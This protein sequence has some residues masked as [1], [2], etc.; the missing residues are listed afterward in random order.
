VRLDRIRA[1]RQKPGLLR[2][3]LTAVRAATTIAD[4]TVEGAVLGSRALTFAPR[5]VRAGEYTF[6]VGSAG[7][8]TLVLQTVLP[9]LLVASGSSVL[10]LEGGTH[11]PAAPPLT[12]E[13]VFVAR[14]PAGSTGRDDDRSKGLLSRGRRAIHRAHSAGDQPAAP[15]S[16]RARRDHRTFGTR[17]SPISRN[18]L[19]TGNWRRRCIS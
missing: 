17:S 15:R 9:A 4:A 1:G 10:T 7:S 18:T 12:F 11:N 13:H 8:A 19:R 14:Q 16:D 3:H 6:S 2:Q 5:R